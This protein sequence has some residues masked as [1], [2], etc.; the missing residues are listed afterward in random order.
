MTFAN[1]PE[2]CDI[3]CKCRRCGHIDRLNRRA[4]AARFGKGQRIRRLERRMRCKKCENRAG[5]TIFVGKPR[6]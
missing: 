5:N 4:L 1:L 6:R 3:L 2:W